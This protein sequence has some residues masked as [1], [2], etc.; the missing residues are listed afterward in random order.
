MPDIAF[1]EEWNKAGCLPFYDRVLE[2]KTIFKV[3]YKTALSRLG[4][5]NNNFIK[6]FNFFNEEY[7]KKYFKPINREMEEIGFEEEPLPMFDILSESGLPC[8]VKKA[9]FEQL[10]SLSRGAEILR[11]KVRKMIELYSDWWKSII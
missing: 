11:I 10:I 4:R 6:L 9:V 8:L 7:Q 5:K 3:S 1:N 2:V